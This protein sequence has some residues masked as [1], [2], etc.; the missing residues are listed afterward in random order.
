MKNGSGAG[1]L[2]PPEVCLLAEGRTETPKKRHKPEKIVAKLR[3]WCNYKSGD[4]ASLEFT[5]KHFFDVDTQNAIRR[6]RM[7]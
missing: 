3:G 6:E 5:Y 2:V 1:E 4:I 7:K